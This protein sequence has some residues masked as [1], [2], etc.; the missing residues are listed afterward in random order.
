MAQWVKDPTTA[1]Q[2]TKKAWVQ[3]PAW[4]SRLK[5]LALPQL[6]CGSQLWL[7]FN[8]RLRN[9]HMSQMPSLKKPK[10]QKNFV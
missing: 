6:W 7:R 10:T 4:H 3:S 2:V 8:P 1:A 5:D 9:F